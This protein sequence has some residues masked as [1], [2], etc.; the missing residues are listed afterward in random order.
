MFKQFKEWKRI[1]ILNPRSV[2]I[3]VVTCIVS[4]VCALL[5]PL[6][7]SHFISY[8]SSGVFNLAFLWLAIDLALKLLEQL[9]WHFNYSNY[10]KL[11]APTYLSLQE[12]LTLVALEPLPRDKNFELDYV[13]S[14]DLYVI[15]NFIDR[16]ILRLCNLIKLIAVS[17]VIFYYSYA[18]GTIILVVSI[19]G[20]FILSFY[21]SQNKK[22]TKSLYQ[23]EKSVTKKFDEIQA[24]RDVIKKYNLENA[25][26]Y[27]ERRRLSSYVRGYQSTTKSRSVKDN[28]LQIYWYI[29]VAVCIAILVYEFRKASLTLTIFLTLYNYLLMYSKITENLFDF[30]IETGELAVS[31]ERFQSVLNVD[32]EKEK[33]VLTEVKDISL[34]RVNARSN[35]KDK[36]VKIPCGNVAV[37]RSSA[38][39][40]FFK[41]PAKD[42]QINGIDISEIDF[43]KVC[44]MVS[45]DNE[46]F[47]DS[48]IENMQIISADI[49]KISSLLQL[50]GLA[51]Y[52]DN[53]PEKEY[54]NIVDSSDESINF[55]FNLVRAILSDAKIIFLDLSK[56]ADDDLPSI[57]KTVIP[58]KNNRIFLILDE[59]GRINRKKILIVE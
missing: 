11:I 12:R 36:N 28:L 40:K 39:Q 10:T 49:K 43:N 34:P 18:I 8:I 57:M 41:L 58:V 46:M 9:S 16:L 51:K 55:K 50:V 47:D 37:F 1:V 32:G 23:K 33:Q 38:Y 20:F 56:L 14:N 7:L 21:T 3:Q 6:A 48:I 31:L 44:K 24:K 54:T 59:A 22:I 52:I 19:L 53:L 29:M 45:Y 13:I 30:K 5:S 42:F 2:T 27:E 26:A 17:A 15:S 4:V 35:A 25:V